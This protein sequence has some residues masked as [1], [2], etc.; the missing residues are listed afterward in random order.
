MFFIIN[1]GTD[2]FYCMNIWDKYYCKW[3]SFV[4]NA[5]RRLLKEDWFK[6]KDISLI[7]SYVRLQHSTQYFRTINIFTKDIIIFE[8]D[9]Y[10]SIFTQAYDK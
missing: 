1:Y 9:L 7:L 2:C 8:K 10:I 5:L 4:C 6:V 3:I